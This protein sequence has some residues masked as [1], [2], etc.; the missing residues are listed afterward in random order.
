MAPERGARTI[1]W[2]RDERTTKYESDDFVDAE[3]DD[4]DS[5][6]SAVR[7]R[8]SVEKDDGWLT[9]EDNDDDVQNIY[10]PLSDNKRWMNRWRLLDQVGQ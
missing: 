2:H 4:V 1:T 10:P 5:S 8:H 9:E 6:L 3:E 7:G